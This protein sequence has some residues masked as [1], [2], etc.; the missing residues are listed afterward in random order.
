MV[1]DSL[2]ACV[3]Y[4]IGNLASLNHLAN[5][6]LDKRCALLNKFDKFGVALRLQAQLLHLPNL[7]QENILVARGD[8]YDVIH[9]QLAQYSSLDLHLLDIVLPL[10]FGTRLNLL[11]AVDIHLLEERNAPLVEVAV[12][13]EWCR[14]L[15]V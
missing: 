7:I 5:Q 4:H 8:R 14:S 9:R 15:A 2:C 1:G 13:N 10:D 11:V 3:L 12:K 6:L